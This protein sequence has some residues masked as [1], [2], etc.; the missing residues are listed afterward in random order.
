M[1]TLAV[2]RIKLGDTRH[3]LALTIGEATRSSLS[4]RHFARRL[5][6]WLLAR[7]DAEIAGVRRAKRFEPIV[8][9]AQIANELDL[10]IVVVVANARIVG[11]QLVGVLRIWRRRR[12][13]VLLV[14]MQIEH[15]INVD[16]LERRQLFEKRQPEARRL[17]N[18]INKFDTLSLKF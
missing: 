6:W 17:Y 4:L 3:D 18:S 5:S 10:V 14:A 8:I 1:R 13:F 15:H 12:L 7:I 2:D 9:G 11:E 16:F